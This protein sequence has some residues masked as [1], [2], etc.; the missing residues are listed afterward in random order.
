METLLGD[1]QEQLSNG[2]YG[3]LNTEILAHEMKCCTPG[4]SL[5]QCP[6]NR[7]PCYLIDASAEYILSF[8]QLHL[9]QILH[10]E[11]DTVLATANIASEKVKSSHYEYSSTRS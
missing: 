3:S 1:F 6:E 9:F 5:D 7:C 2:I 8:E 11:T 10:P 4:L